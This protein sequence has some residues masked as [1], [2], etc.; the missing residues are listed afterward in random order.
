MGNWNHPNGRTHHTIQ[1]RAVL[2][3]VF[4]TLHMRETALVLA[5]DHLS[6]LVQLVQSA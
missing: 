5:L 6:H 1:A 2:P 4:C 3:N